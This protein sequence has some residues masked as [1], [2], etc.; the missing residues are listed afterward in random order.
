LAL[1]TVT[2]RVTDRRQFLQGAVGLAS[3]TLLG[4]L[5]GC[6]DGGRPEAR[7]PRPTVPS[8]ASP[9][10]IEALDP[11]AWSV[12][13]RSLD[14]TLV[15]PTAAGY[16]E[17]KLVYNLR[18][19][20]AD[21]VAVAY[22]ATATDVQRCV[23]FARAHGLTP[24]ARSGGHSYAGYS[25]GTGLVIDVSPMNAVTTAAGPMTAVIGS[26]AQLVDVYAAVAGAGMLL[27][28]GSCPTVGIAGLTLGGGIGVVG[29]KYG[30]T[31]DNLLALDAVTADGRL[32]T[33]RADENPD[34]FWAS[35]GGGGG[36]FGIAT[37]FTFGLHPL[38]EL[39]LFTVN[40][41]W[42]AAGAVLGQWQEWTASAPDE[43]WSNCQ[44]QSAGS[45][46]LNVR[47]N[48]VYVGAVGGLTTVLQPLLDRAGTPTNQFVG[49]DSY[50][51]A[52]LVEAGCEDLSV[53]QCH[54]SD[55][56]TAGTLARSS[57]AA[58]SSYL[59]TAM[60]DAGVGA[61]VAAVEHLQDSTPSLGGGLV[62]D[63]YGG[64][65]NAVA[66][67]ATAFVHRQ[68]LCAL[69]ASVSWAPATAPT[70]VEAAQ[71]WLAGTAA[72]LAPFV[73]R[74]AY[75]NYIDPTLVDW[76]EAYYG[77]NL[78]RL[79]ELKRR[80]DPEDVFHFAQSIPTELGGRAGGAPASLSG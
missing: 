12:L 66:P 15:L 2:G 46:G 57:F 63:A 61:A 74:S 25:T 52:M 3:A 24:I 23:G 18:F 38:P 73:S 28:A 71:S 26:G 48:G 51:H 72:S 17:A 27:P 13:A 62:F 11:A 68:E 50:L 34:L 56:S 30:L 40:W 22:C 47:I 8:S 21:P 20:D 65:I 1:E 55:P 49:P 59:T 77:S 4:S 5:A 42:E 10:T 76:A 45:D 80:Y 70:L 43:L 29:R 67:T 64:A 33:C 19:T 69:Q 35:R 75:Q 78:P 14:G 44:L 36:N 58:T 32:L 53:A 16:A 79:V 39:A 31:C 37:S 9:S 6:G 54:L 7:R 41:P 60:T